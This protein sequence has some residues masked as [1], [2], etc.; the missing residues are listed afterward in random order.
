[1]T[2]IG[3]IAVLLA[4]VVAVYSAVAAVL[5]TREGFPELVASARRGAYA[6][7]ALVTLA[8]LVLAYALATSDFGLR[9]VYE[10]TSLD[11]A[12][13]YKLSALYAGNDGSLLFWAWILSLLS[14]VVVYRNRAERTFAPYVLATTMTILAFFTLL[15][16]LVASPFDRIPAAVDGLGMNPMLENVGMLIHPPALYLGYVGLTI[17]FAFAVAALV[18]GKLDGDWLRRARGWALFAWLMLGVGNVLGGQ[19]AYAELGW[20]GYW[21]WDPVENA[22]LMPWLIATA[23]LHAALVQKRR[24]MFRVWSMALVTASFLLAIFGTFITRSG[25]ISSVHA[26]GQSSLGP[27]FLTFLGLVTVFSAGLIIWRL[28]TLGQGEEL[29]SFWSRENWVLITNIILVG[30]VLAVMF[31]TLYPLFSEMVGGRK[32]ELGKDFYN[33]VDGPFLLAV[34]AVLGICPILAWRR[35][36]NQRLVR[37]LAVSAG[38]AVVVGVVLAVLGVRQLIP[39]LAFVICAFVIFSHAGEW[40]RGTRAR[41]RARGINP[42]AALGGMVWGNRP[43]YGA[44][45]VHVA[46]AVIAIGVVGSTFFVSQAEANLKVGETMT[47][48]GYTLKYEGMAEDATATREMVSA[49]LSVWQGDR[50]LG[51]VR[52]E[53]IFHQSSDQPVSEVAINTNLREDLYVILAGWTADGTASFKVL[54]NPLIVWIWIGG[55]LL[56]LGGL[57]AAWPETRALTLPVVDDKLEPAPSAA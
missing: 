35:S 3:Y 56:L 15:V 47:V 10:H 34:I 39:L 31:G 46:M 30:S 44:H 23:Y 17:P 49:T 50:S 29:E 7:G 36:D 14:A 41:Q 5:G 1:M 21:A 28:P 51:A 8:V 13:A 52:P 55:G 11:M 26:Y 22:S 42:L 2:D 27:F 9:Y 38:L 54:I 6:V 43:R 37:G 57:I 33:Q 32:I 45:V 48:G 24:P 53:M 40:Y 18:T 16:A 19:W 4:F 12:L 25:I 20:G